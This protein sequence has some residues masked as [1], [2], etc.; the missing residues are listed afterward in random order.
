MRHYKIGQFSRR[1]HAGQSREENGSTVIQ[2]F[3]L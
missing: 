3:A 2:E 1:G